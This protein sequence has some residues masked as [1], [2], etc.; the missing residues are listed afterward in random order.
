MEV[1]TFIT[2][3]V[4]KKLNTL[5][6]LDCVSEN[7]YL[8]WCWKGLQIAY[9][10]ADSLYLPISKTYFLCQSCRQEQ[11]RTLINDFWLCWKVHSRQQRLQLWNTFQIITLPFFFLLLILLFSDVFILFFIVSTF[12][13]LILCFISFSFNGVF[14]TLKLS[15]KGSRYEKNSSF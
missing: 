14:L 10:H 15:S 7:D 5:W 8:G 1:W 13:A 2:Q 11:F 6:H 4:Q 12:S 9:Q 3:R